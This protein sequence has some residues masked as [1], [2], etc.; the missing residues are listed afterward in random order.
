MKI[1]YRILLKL[2]ASNFYVTKKERQLIFDNMKDDVL[3]A[4]AD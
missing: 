1:I 3:I 2:E 4:E